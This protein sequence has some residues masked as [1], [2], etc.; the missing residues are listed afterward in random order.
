MKILL[1]FPDRD[2]LL[3]VGDYLRLW[4]LEVETAFDALQASSRLAEEAYD[5]VI[6]DEKIPRAPWKDLANLAREKNTPFLLLTGAV[7]AQIPPSPER[8]ENV[9][10]YP[11]FPRELLEKIRK[12]CPD[13]PVF[14]TA[15][16]ENE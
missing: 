1:A 11:F 12:I 3:S 10:R 5:L 14:E 9:L 2:L 13:S 15:G 7:R 4:N 16:D 6:A 8:E